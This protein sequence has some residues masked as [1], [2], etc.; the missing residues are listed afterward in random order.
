MQL[1]EV[2]AILGQAVRNVGSRL[3][4]DDAELYSVDEIRKHVQQKNNQV[5][6]RL[7]AF[8]NDYWQWFNFHR[9]IE[10]QGKSGNLDWD[11][12]DQLISLIKNRDT[13]RQE[14]LK[15]LPVKT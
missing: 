10:A 15:I 1:S 13:A 8:I 11:E 2:E 4:V 12:N 5:S 14:L 7:E 9:R 3:D 6:E